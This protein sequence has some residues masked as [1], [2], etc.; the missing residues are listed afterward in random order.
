MWSKSQATYNI[1]NYY[2]MED[3]K[4]I[5]VK[6]PL[7]S[8][9]ISKEDSLLIDYH[10]RNAKYNN[11]IE[12]VISEINRIQLILGFSEI[13]KEEVINHNN[14]TIACPI[15]SMIIP[16]D[17]VNEIHRIAVAGEDLKDGDVVTIRNGIALKATPDSFE[18]CKESFDIINKMASD[19][20]KQIKDKKIKDT[21]EEIKCLKQKLK[22][23]KDSE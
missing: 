12:E 20:A 10:L 9:I 19:L 1:N 7:G 15:G 22:R 6:L 14:L 4:N 18:R 2:T 16:P 17:N 5:T 11:N 3:K 13:I 23:L 8:K 21:K